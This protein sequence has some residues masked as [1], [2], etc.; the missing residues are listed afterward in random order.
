VERSTFK[1]SI[2]G[3][4]S[5][6]A[7]LAMRVLE[8]G[9]ADVVLLDLFGNIAKGK[10]LDLLDAAPLAG[11]ENN[12]IGT[13]KYEDT[14]SS[15]IVVVTAGLARKPG[16][17]REDL[18]LKNAAIIKDVS[19]NIKKYS[20]DAIVIVVTNPLDAMTYLARRVTGFDRRRIF[21]MA[22]E[23]DGSRLITL[24]SDELKVPRASVTTYMLGSHG[25]TMVPV[26]SSTLVSGKPLRGVIPEDRL[27]AIVKRTKDRGAE[28]VSLLGTGSAYYSPSAAVFKMIDAILNDKN[29][30]VTASVCLDG[31]YGLNDISI[32]VPCRLGRRGVTEV[33]TIPL[34]EKEKAEF[35]RSAEAIKDSIKLL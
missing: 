34:D 32:G 35:L 17:T 3:A 26:I 27:A 30:L 18:V 5:V 2:I 11:H 13:D 23:L 4:G 8:S 29:Q 33:V 14:K 12:I 31:E 28:I 7:T 24:V 20:P 15:D 19:N 1:V 21:G 10:A 25:D 16:M 6:G 9:I 22:G